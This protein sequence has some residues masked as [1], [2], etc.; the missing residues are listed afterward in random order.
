MKG[1]CDVGLGMV[2]FAATQ[3]FLHQQYLSLLFS[4][5]STFQE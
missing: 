3:M 5:V 1:A 4:F 2:I